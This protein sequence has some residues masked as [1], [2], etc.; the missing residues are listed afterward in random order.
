MSSKTNEPNEKVK[1]SKQSSS[2]DDTEDTVIGTPSADDLRFLGAPGAYV[3][4]PTVKNI[5]N[6]S[7]IEQSNATVVDIIEDEANVTIIESDTTNASNTSSIQTM[8]WTGAGAVPKPKQRIVID[9]SLGDLGLQYAIPFVEK[10]SGSGVIVRDGSKYRQLLP[11]G[12]NV[13]RQSDAGTAQSTMLLE[14]DS[15][16]DRRTMYIDGLRRMRDRVRAANTGI[17][18]KHAIALQI[19]NANKYWEKF[20]EAHNDVYAATNTFNDRRDASNL[21]CEIE[22]LHGELLAELHQRLEEC[23][24]NLAAPQLSSNFGRQSEV[25]LP[26]VSIDPFGGDFEKW[27]AFKSVFMNYFSQGYTK[28]AKMIYLR[29]S[30]IEDSEAYNLIAGLEP[31]AENFDVAWETLCNTYDDVRRILEQAFCAL[32]DVQQIP[33][34]ATRAALLNLV[35]RTK[36]TMEIMSK[37]GVETA[38]WGPALVP[39]L[40]SSRY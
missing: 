3:K 33:T 25:K 36:N 4:V 6:S 38:T 18:S 5:V 26:A 20:L 9:K 11:D 7:V 37:Y 24:I 21:H 22:T 12:K 8:D 30:M 40:R 19:E 15:G 39:Y 35:T 23:T 27:P 31:N 29:Q 17:V 32:L 14:S 34:P 2:T 1:P 10:S 16:H 28:H 13:S